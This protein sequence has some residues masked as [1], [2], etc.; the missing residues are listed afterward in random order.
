MVVSLNT[1]QYSL[2]GRSNSVGQ[3]ALERDLQVGQGGLDFIDFRLVGVVQ[4]F[5]RQGW[6]R[7]ASASGKDS[8]L[9]TKTGDSP[10]TRSGRGPNPS[11]SLSL[12]RS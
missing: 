1:N 8:R 7:S 11:K 6:C 5:T 4:R 10:P 3:S 2:Y 12:S 9:K